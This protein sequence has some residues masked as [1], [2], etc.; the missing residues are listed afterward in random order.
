MSRCDLGI[1]WASSTISC[2]IGCRT[3]FKGRLTLG[4]SSVGVVSREVREEVGACVDI[5]IETGCHYHGKT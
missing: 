3:T 2:G 4:S 1:G 5:V